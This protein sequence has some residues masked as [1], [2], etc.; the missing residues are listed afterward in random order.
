MI[1]RQIEMC[2]AH[3]FIL[4]I[5]LVNLIENGTDDYPPTFM[6]FLIVLLNPSLNLQTFP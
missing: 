5:K 2:L 1:I 6:E 3:V 4:E